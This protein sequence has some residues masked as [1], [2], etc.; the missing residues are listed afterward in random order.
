M[1]PRRNRGVCVR[2]ALA[3]LGSVRVRAGRRGRSAFSLLC[4][5]GH[6]ADFPLTDEHPAEWATRPES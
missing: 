2:R 3:N 4:G 5:P 1:D 6:L